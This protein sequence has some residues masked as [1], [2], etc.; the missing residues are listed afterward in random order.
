MVLVAH[1]DDETLAC[2][3]R[4]VQWPDCTILHT[5]NGSPENLRFARAA[6]FETQVGYAEA[7]RK[8]LGCALALVGGRDTRCFGLVDQQSFV[9]MA[10][11]TRRVLESIEEIRPD[12][13]LSHPYEGGHPDHD[14]A[15]F[16]V[17][18]ACAR[19]G[20]GAPQR[21][22][23]AFYNCLGGVFRPGEFIPG[24]AVEEV[25]LDAETRARKDRMFACFA[26]QQSVLELFSTQYERFRLAP[27]Y[28]F[29][30]A[31]HAGELNY[32]AWGWGLTGEKWRESAARA[33]RE[34]GG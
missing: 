28:D 12:V 11:L 6:G 31:P 33:L 22:E 26:S 8:E 19:I 7:R 20:D 32:E 3:G 24:T 23:A 10:G 29:S 2:G 25:E 17:Q 14:A 16:A 30:Q 1:P 18:H 34:L 27:V 4:M 13:I 9:D 15:A 21:M 5:T